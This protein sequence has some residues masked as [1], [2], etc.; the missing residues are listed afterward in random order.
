MQLEQKI[1]TTE[2]PK[3]EQYLKWKQNTNT[4]I[5]QLKAEMTDPIEDDAMQTLTRI[6]LRHASVHRMFREAKQ[7]ANERFIYFEKQRNNLISISNE[8][9]NVDLSTKDIDF[10]QTF[11]SQ[12]RKTIKKYMKYYGE[13]ETFFHE[14]RNKF[15]RLVHKWEELSYM[16]NN[17]KAIALIKKNHNELTRDFSWSLGRLIHLRIESFRLIKEIKNKEK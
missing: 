13:M 12:I 16:G 3:E 11:R 1:D 2:P 9:T 8:C 4:V 6:E 10:L 14:F 17:K 5:K 15:S 7:I